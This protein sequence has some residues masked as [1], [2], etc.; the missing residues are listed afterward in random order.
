MS[1]LNLATLIFFP[2]KVATE[3]F[4]F[5]IEQWFKGLTGPYTF[6]EICWSEISGDLE[7]SLQFQEET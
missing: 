7:I 4:S 1:I 3:F 2:L 5:N 6:M